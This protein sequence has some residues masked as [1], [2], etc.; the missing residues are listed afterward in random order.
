MDGKSR[1]P[2]LGS[3]V[4][5]REVSTQSRVCTIESDFTKLSKAQ[6]VETEVA[7]VVGTEELI[8]ASVK[9]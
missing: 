8:S 3:A 9:F 4:C 2:A 7:Q 5:A 6:R 1:A